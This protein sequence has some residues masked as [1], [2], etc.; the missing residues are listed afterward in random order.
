MAKLLKTDPEKLSR[1]VTRFTVSKDS[2]SYE[3][4]YWTI[5]TW[6]FDIEIEGS[7]NKKSVIGYGRH[8]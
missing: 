5:Q 7:E 8:Q 2:I 1:M 6:H 3:L 4:T